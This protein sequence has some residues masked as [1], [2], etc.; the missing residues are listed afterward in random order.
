MFQD[1]LK[2]PTLTAAPLLGEGIAF[3]RVV[4]GAVVVGHWCVS[5]SIY[6]DP[7][8][9]VYFLQTVRFAASSTLKG[10]QICA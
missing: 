8:Y 2:V 10:P 9:E 1:L 4:S 5:D 7:F 6:L 3:V